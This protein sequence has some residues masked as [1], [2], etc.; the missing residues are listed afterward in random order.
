MNNIK[1]KFIFLGPNQTLKNP[2]IINNVLCVYLKN[3]AN[4]LLAKKNQSLFELLLNTNNKKEQTDFIKL[5]NNEKFYEFLKEMPNLGVYSLVLKNQNIDNFEAIKEINDNFEN[6]RSGTTLQ[7][8]K[9]ID[10]TIKEIKRIVFKN[11]FLSLEIKHPELKLN[12]IPKKRIIK[13]K[14]K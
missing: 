7:K 8:R 4:F 12:S 2:Q 3:G 5:L 11:Y 6:W 13:P 1:I 10:K 9:V 14:A